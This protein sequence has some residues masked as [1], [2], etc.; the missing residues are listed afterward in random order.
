MTQGAKYFGFSAES[1]SPCSLNMVLWTAGHHPPALWPVPGLRRQS[2]CCY[3]QGRGP[4]VGF[5]A[6][7]ENTWYNEPRRERFCLAQST[8]DCTSCF[9]SVVRQHTVVRACGRAKPSGQ[10]ARKKNVL[11]KKECQGPT[12]SLRPSPRDLRATLK[13]LAL[14]PPPTQNQAYHTGIWGT[15]PPSKLQHT[16]YRQSNSKKQ[17]INLSVQ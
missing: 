14:K 2:F 4:C 16:Y 7:S 15:Q 17:T 8:A 1:E 10:E 13:A 11:K 9:G 5:L 3:A 12:F 6:L